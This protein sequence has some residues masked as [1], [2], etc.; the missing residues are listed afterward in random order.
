[1]SAENEQDWDFDRWSSLEGHPDAHAT[2]E[3]LA[4]TRFNSHREGVSLRVYDRRGSISEPQWVV[5]AEKVDDSGRQVR[6]ITLLGSNSRKFMA[7]EDVHCVDVRYDV[8]R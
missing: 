3:R 5:P 4:K 8:D 7:N 6:G 1:M 2:A